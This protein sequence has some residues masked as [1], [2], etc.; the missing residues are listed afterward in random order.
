MSAGP[1]QE[2]AVHTGFRTPFFGGGREDIFRLP[3]G[4]QTKSYW[5]WLFIVDLPMKNGDFPYS[6]VSLPE[7]KH[8]FR[9]QLM[10]WIHELMMSHWFPSING[11]PHAKI[12]RGF[13]GPLLLSYH[14]AEA[15]DAMTSVKS[16][17]LQ[18]IWTSINLSWLEWGFM[19]VNHG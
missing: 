12:T 5:T 15:I 14:W 17:C 6:Y 7:G 4:K 8:H 16:G 13:T 18:L 2:L 19:M 3:S 9:P 10:F 1:A 11:T